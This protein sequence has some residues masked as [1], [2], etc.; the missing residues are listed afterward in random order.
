MTVHHIAGQ[1]H[2]VETGHRRSRGDAALHL[3][4]RGKGADRREEVD[5]LVAEDPHRR[6][7]A[8]PDR[9][10]DV[11][12]QRR[13]S[14]VVLLGDAAHRPESSQN[15]LLRKQENHRRGLSYAILITVFYIH[16]QLR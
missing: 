11:G 1:D 8:G 12:R 5:R 2:E 14:A 10:N 13:P 4:R 16:L 15:R 7:D 3:R 9:Q 6:K